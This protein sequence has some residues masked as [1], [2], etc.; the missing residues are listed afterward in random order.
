MRHSGYVSP[1]KIVEKDFHT[2][3]KL[4]KLYFYLFRQSYLSSSLW[5]ILLNNKHLEKWK[6]DHLIGM[7]IHWI[8]SGNGYSW[9]VGHN[10]HPNQGDFDFQIGNSFTSCLALLV[11]A[12]FGLPV[13]ELM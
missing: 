4:I 5:V 11:I 13:L 3:I 7:D 8:S 1:M 10:I 6:F 2:C 12:L 9:T